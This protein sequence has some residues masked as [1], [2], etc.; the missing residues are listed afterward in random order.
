ML[1]AGTLY[2]PKSGPVV[3]SLGGFPLASLA[4]PSEAQRRSWYVQIVCHGPGLIFLDGTFA[5]VGGQIGN[6]LTRA[7]ADQ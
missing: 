1:I 3:F 6:V 2:F 7:S 5:V 4:P